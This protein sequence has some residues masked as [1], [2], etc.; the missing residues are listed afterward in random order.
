MF[1]ILDTKPIDTDKALVT[2]ACE[3]GDTKPTGGFVTG[4]ACIELDPS[5]N[6]VKAYFYSES[7][8]SWMEVSE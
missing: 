2:A 8:E 3:A 5:N 1:R 6:A 7:D 4:S